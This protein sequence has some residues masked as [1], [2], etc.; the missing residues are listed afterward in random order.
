MTEHEQA[1]ASAS[2]I[3]QH[4]YYLGLA[5][6]VAVIL[7]AS[8]LLFRSEPAEEVV[9]PQ[10][11]VVV[12]PLP[13]AETE[14]LP[15]DEPEP[16]EVVETEPVIEPLPEPLVETDID[17]TDVVTEPVEP[18]P[19]LPQLNE[20]D[21]E[22]R[23][24]LLELSWQPGLAGLFVQ[25]ELIRRFVVLADNVSRGHIS[26]ELQVVQQPDAPFVAQQVDDDMYRLD[27]AGYQRYEPYLTLLESVPVATQVELLQQYQPLFEEAF[28]ELGYPDTPFNQRLVQ[29]IDYVLD[30]PVR[31]GVF[32]L[33]RPSVM[34]QFADADLEAMTDVQK[35]LIRMGPDNQQRLQ[36]LLHKLRQALNE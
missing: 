6:V 19:A 31:D 7:I 3:G 1:P 29:A 16:V 18:E 33:E 35:Q 8:W 23:S 28:N 22:V 21:A 34:Y 26:N 24:A 4:Y 25:E 20:S 14:A 27:P 17:T 13:Q 10:P 30:Q 9:S 32:M 5:A 2:A 12:E 15:T 11:P 36:A